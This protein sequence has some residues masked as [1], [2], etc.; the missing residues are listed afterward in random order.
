MGLLLQLVDLIFL[1][2]NLSIVLRVLF[3]YI[4]P[5]PYNPFVRAVV[6]VTD[7]ILV[8][9]RRVIPPLGMFDITPFVAL[10]LLGIVQSAILG[11]LR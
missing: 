5:D 11:L 10:I 6:D 4:N 3:S 2:L 8:P 1:A 9:L 7:R